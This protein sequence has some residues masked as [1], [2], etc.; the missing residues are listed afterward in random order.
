[1][2]SR[3]YLMYFYGVDQPGLNPLWSDADATRPVVACGST[4]LYGTAPRIFFSQTTTGT[5]YLDFKQNWIPNT[6]HAKGTTAAYIDLTTFSAGF[7]SVKKWF[8]E[9]V[10]NVVDATSA[11]LCQIWY[12]IDEGAW[13]QMID[14]TGSVVALTLSATNKAAF[15]PLNTTGVNIRLRL[16]LYT[17]SGSAAQAAVTAVTIRGIVEPKKRVQISFPVVAD[18]TEQG[19][20]DLAEDSGRNLKAAFDEMV[21]SGYPVKFQDYDKN[22]YLVEFRTP[23]PLEAITS[24]KEPQ[25]NR[26]A[27]ANRV[28]NVLLTVI[29]QLDSS[30][31]TIAWTPG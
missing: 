10:L 31:N 17:A 26:S 3:A 9:V 7:R 20:F 29:D 5:G 14:E 11:T 25:G 19:Y 30:G 23:Y 4:D 8:Y 15:F 1:M 28:F 12:S 16:Y 18:D 27:E 24:L 13:T 6:Y 22:W 2:Q 21:T